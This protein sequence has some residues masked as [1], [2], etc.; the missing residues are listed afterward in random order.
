[1][2]L[3][4]HYE[5]RGKHAFLSPSSPYWLAYDENKLV[6]SYKNS[7]AKEIGTRKHAFAA[8]AIALGEKLQRSKRTLPMYVNDA[9]G[10]GMIPEQPVYYSDNCYGT[11]DALSFKKNF[12]RIHDLK[13][14][15]TP[16]KMDQ[17]RVYA[18]LFCLEY[19]V[20]PKSIGSELRIYQND[21]ILVCNPTPE[22]LIDIMNHIVWADSIVE[23]VKMDIRPR[24]EI[25]GM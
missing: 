8:E 24:Y 9:I 10:F 5:L 15:E 17:L 12:L 11:A 7:M 6:T 3:N 22:E 19:N 21:E 1:M 14:G 13:T 20:D 4:P 23:R 25:G 18:S 2:N 16:G